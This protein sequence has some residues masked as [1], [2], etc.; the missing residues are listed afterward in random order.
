[1]GG[2]ISN[3]YFSVRTF[4]TCD[5][6]IIRTQLFSPNP[7]VLLKVNRGEY[8]RLELISPQ[9]PCVVLKG[10]ELVGTIIHK[11]LLQLIECMN[12]GAEFHALVRD[13]TGGLCTV[14]ILKK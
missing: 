8:L 12:K 7:D 1:M 3:R 9:G 10:N 6:L 2:G 14:T 4:I 11:Y 5:D 13:I